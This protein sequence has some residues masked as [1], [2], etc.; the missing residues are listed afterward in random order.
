MYS[1][2]KQYARS[3]IKRSPVFREEV[4]RL[5]EL[6]SPGASGG[7]TRGNYVKL[8]TKCSR[9]IVPPPWNKDDLLQVLHG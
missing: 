4:K 6:V 3:K 7:L 9:L 1:E 5:W 2:E 8:I